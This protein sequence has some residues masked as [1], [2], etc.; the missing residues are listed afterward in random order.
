M[1]ET[2]E[3][4]NKLISIGAMMS[5]VATAILSLGLIIKKKN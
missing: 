4:Q 1:P 2:G 5:A 3:K